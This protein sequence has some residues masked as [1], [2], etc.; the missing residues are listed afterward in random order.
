[1][2]HD[3]VHQKKLEQHRRELIERGEQAK[4]A[5]DP[6]CARRVYRACIAQVQ[7][8]VYGFF[9]G[10]HVC[11]SEPVI[12]NAGMQEYGFHLACPSFRENL[13]QMQMLS[14]PASGVLQE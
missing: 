7:C 14:A 1:M 2:A 13:P 9:L 3:E 5:L 8:Q 11:C 12:H 4:P 6:L 10:T